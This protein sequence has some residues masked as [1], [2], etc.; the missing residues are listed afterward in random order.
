MPSLR[1]K[2]LCF[3]YIVKK[4]TLYMNLYLMLLGG[5]GGGGVGLGQSGDTFFK[6]TK[7]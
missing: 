3:V 7:L 6:L 5:G 2:N 4:Q 1:A